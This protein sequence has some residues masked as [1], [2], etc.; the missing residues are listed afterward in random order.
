[1]GPRRQA[2]RIAVWSAFALLATVLPTTAQEPLPRSLGQTIYV[3]VYSHVWHGNIITRRGEA[4]RI[5]VSTLVS[6][7]NIDPKRSIRIEVVRYFDSQG[8]LIR[9]YI[10]A[11]QEVPAFGAAEYFVE[12]MDRSGGS[13]ANFLIKWTAATPANPPLVEAVTVYFHGTRAFAFISPGR[14]IRTD[15]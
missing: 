4:E 7:R 8:K 11:P 9:D 6:V 5:D 2:I 15:E 13:G 1:M 12:Q 14:V 3:P 10:T